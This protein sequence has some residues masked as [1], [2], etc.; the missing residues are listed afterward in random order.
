MS[1]QRSL[2]I[3][4]DL[5]GGVLGLVTTLSHDL[6]GTIRETDAEAL[7]LATPHGGFPSWFGGQGAWLGRGI[8]EM[9]RGRLVEIEGGIVFL[10]D[11][12]D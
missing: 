7:V 3:I 5:D 6:G 1:L 10:G 9:G 11:G 8:L 4:G 2:A 12:R